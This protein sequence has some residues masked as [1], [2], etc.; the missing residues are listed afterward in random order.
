MGLIAYSAAKEE[1]ADKEA[2][3]KAGPPDAVLVEQYKAPERIS[4]F[5]EV[6]LIAQLDVKKTILVLHDAK[7][8]ED[9]PD[10]FIAHVIPLYAVTAKTRE[11]Q[12][13]YGSLIARKKMQTVDVA[14]M[15]VVQGG[16]APIVRINGKL[17]TGLANDGEEALR[18]G[19]RMIADAVHI[20][21][22]MNGRDDALTIVDD[23]VDA[24]MAFLV[25]AAGFA[26]WGGFRR[27]RKFKNAK[28]EEDELI[29]G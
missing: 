26:I 29:Y 10:N 22:F 27:W 3:R 21:A 5:H 7:L 25:I 6:S 18:N 2:A 12:P 8:G 4:G 16:F 13:A 23:A 19:P 17:E 14:A 1:M 9:A 15:R 11:G 28:E 20:E 24:L